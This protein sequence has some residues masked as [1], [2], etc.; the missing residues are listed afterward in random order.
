MSFVYHANA[1][2]FGGVIKKPGCDV[3]PS[4][5]SVVLAP[6]GGEGWQTV[7]NFNYKDIITFDEASAYVGGSQKGRYRNTVATTMIRNLNLM[8]MIQIELLVARVTS[9]HLAVDDKEQSPSGEPQF[10][11]EGSLMENVRIAGRRA[12]VALDPSVFSRYNTYSSFV[13]AFG[14]DASVEDRLLGRQTTAEMAGPLAAR[15][16]Q[17]F[18]W[19]ADQCQK[20]APGKNGVFRCSLVEG[21]PDIPETNE[22]FSDEDVTRTNDRIQPVR[23]NGYIVRIADFGTVAI[24]EVLLK[25]HQRT[26]NMLRLNLGSP[27]DGSGT[28]CSGTTNGTDIMP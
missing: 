13:Q 6:S 19:P 27:I 20:G 23:R 3:I 11:F 26:V 1:L 2:A 24:G 10:T 7:R 12:E 14:E 5:A 15:Y 25:D 9:E 17:R 28:A 16:A 18:C 4:Q 21:I 22:D 8:N